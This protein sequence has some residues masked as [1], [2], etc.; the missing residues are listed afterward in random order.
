MTVLSK[1]FLYFLEK[2]YP[3][4][5]RSGVGDIP[6]SVANSLMS[7]YGQKYKI[8]TEIPDWI[9]NNYG[10]KIPKE[11]LNGN[12]TVRDYIEKEQDKYKAEEKAT[13][14][15]IGYSVSMLALGYM[16]DTVTTLTQDRAEREA[17][18]K[19]AGGLGL[20][21]EQFARW[22]ATRQKDINAITQDWQTNQPEK[23]ALHLAKSISRAKKQMAKDN[24]TEEDK[25]E[26][27]AKIKKLEKELKS[28]SSKL[29]TRGLKQN[30]VDYLRAQPQQA[31]LRH[32]EPDTLSLLTKLMGKQGIKIEAV[33]SSKVNSNRLSSVYESLTSSLKKDFEA[34]E[35]NSTLLH[36]A[37]QNGR[38][39]AERITARATQKDKKKKSKTRMAQAKRMSARQN[40]AG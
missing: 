30:M 10:G 20:T 36:Q 11:V 37:V 8:Y 4:A 18:L 26:L 23:Y 21:P 31:A 38:K 28:F 16:T 13:N 12:V 15:L 33:Q 7:E 3:S 34:M 6:E 17:I 2:N 40:A 27:A 19:E 9:K 24:V 25:A 39:T 5:Y 22:L 35:K 14:E 1:D 29:D 32:L